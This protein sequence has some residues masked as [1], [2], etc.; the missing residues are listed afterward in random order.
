MAKKQYFGIKYPFL[1]DYFQHFYAIASWATFSS[2]AFLYEVFLQ[3]NV[4]HYFC[5][6]IYRVGNLNDL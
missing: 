3:V 1:R 5:E 4:I 2:A 6:S